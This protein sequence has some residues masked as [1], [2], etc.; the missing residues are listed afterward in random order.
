METRVKLGD[1]A[2]DFEGTTSDGTKL[3]LNDFLGKKNVVLYFY[4]KDDTENCT[5]EACNFRDNLNSIRT[6]WTEVVGVS[7]DSI[8]SHR[9]FSQKHQIT[10]PLVSDEEKKIAKAYGVLSKDGAHVE[11]VTFII[12]RTG[13]VVKIFPQVDV[14]KHTHQVVEALKLMTHRPN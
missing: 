10:F 5:I 9:E 7:L 14:T 8:Q 1:L 11:R 13:R 6:M 2:P 4:P 12:D 3:R